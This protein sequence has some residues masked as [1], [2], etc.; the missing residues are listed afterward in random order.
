MKKKASLAWNE[1]VKVILFFILL[2]LVYNFIQ[3]LYSATKSIPEWA[4][5]LSSVEDAVNNLDI[6]YPE[7]TRTANV[8]LSGK[9]LIKGFSESTGICPENEKKPHCICACSN[10]ECSNINGKETKYCR[11]I[12]L[13]PS[14]DFLIENSFPDPV[15]VKIGLNND[16]KVKRLGII[17]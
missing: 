8:K 17:G 6:L 13:E 3:N 1:L 7:E 15:G 10:P 16:K 2:I 5:S 9:Y 4:R 11:S 14:P 12:K